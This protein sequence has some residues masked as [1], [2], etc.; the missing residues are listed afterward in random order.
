MCGI[1]L[2]GTTLRLVEREINLFEKLL[3]CD[4]L[5]GSHSTG[6]IAGFSLPND[7]HFSKI[8]KTAQT[9]PDFLDSKVWKET[10]VHQYKQTPVSTFDVTQQPNY[11]VG[12]NR[13]ATMGAKTAVNAHPFQ[14]EHIKLVHNGTLSDQSLL[15]DHEKF[16]VD[17]NNI[18]HAIAVQG[19]E[20]TIQQ[21]NGAFTLI[22]VDDKEQT[23]NIIRNDER[24]F[25]LAETIS[26]TWFGASEEEMLMW[27]IQRD[28]KYSITKSSPVL[29][30]HF[31]CEVGTQ[32]VFDVSKGEFSLINEIKHVLPTFSKYVA[33]LSGYYDYY[34][35]NSNPIAHIPDDYVDPR[36]ALFK[37]AGLGNKGI[38]DFV[39]YLAYDFKPYPNDPFR[40]S[41]CGMLDD[42]QTLVEI[43]NHGFNRSEFIS[44]RYY[45][46]EIRGIFEDRGVVTL[47]VRES[48]VS[49]DNPDEWDE[50]PAAMDLVV[51]EDSQTFTSESWLKSEDSICKNCEV[52]IPFDEAED[53]KAALRGYVCNQCHQSYVVEEVTMSSD[54]PFPD[55]TFICDECGE[56]YDNEEK[57]T[58]IEGC[59]WN[60]SGFDDEDDNDTPFDVFKSKERSHDF[61]E[62]TWLDVNTCHLCEETIPFEKAN[63]CMI[64]VKGLT[65]CNK[66]YL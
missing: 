66:C 6:V 23:L 27:I 1:V 11:L 17:S 32:Y 2:A 65:T 19:A 16:E 63:T 53:A 52:Q 33:P 41:I 48:V 20:K 22:W 47:L 10:K 18:C 4:T 51:M 54:I 50:E 62:E 9:G 46:A 31:E 43:I 8:G 55:E 12:H 60:C 40:G 28:D 29:K 15:P 49:S 56:E 59:C 14:C 42:Q 37:R 45:R 44:E 64:T 25:H 35:Y 39:S 30:R 61:T 21:L 7:V 3:Y 13:Y 57:S 38:G 24:P 34:R 36:A 5:R 26:G 58:R